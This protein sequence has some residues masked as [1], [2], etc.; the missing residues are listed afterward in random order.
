MD[1][2]KLIGLNQRTIGSLEIQSLD[3][4]AS[5]PTMRDLLPSAQVIGI[6][7][8]KTTGGGVF[9][10]QPRRLTPRGEMGDTKRFAAIHPAGFRAEPTISSCRLLTSLLRSPARPFLPATL[11]PK[12]TR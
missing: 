6:D 11:R 2:M 1:Y 4:W 10:V 8:E 5:P 7:K 12:Q 9:S 3:A